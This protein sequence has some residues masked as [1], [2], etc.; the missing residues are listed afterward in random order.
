MGMKLWE[1]TNTPKLINELLDQPAA[2]SWKTKSNTSW[3]AVFQVEDVTY[4]VFL[5]GPDSREVELV[6]TDSD[7]Q[8]DITGSG[9]AFAVFATVAAILRDFLKHRK[10]VAVC[11]SAKEASRAKLYKRLA[12][13]LARE[14]KG[15]V[16]NYSDGAAQG[17]KIRLREDGKIIPGVNTTVDVK[18]GETNRQAEKFGNKLDAKG[19]PPLLCGSYGDDSARFSANHGDPFYGSDGTR[20]TGGRK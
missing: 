4:W 7:H 13:G 20:L 10:P 14:A 17:F 8:E 15:R 9:N 1:L 18:P 5:D 3:E 6:F 12:D 2:F 16:I 19:R 11:F